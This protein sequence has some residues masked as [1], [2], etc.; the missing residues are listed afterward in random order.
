MKLGVS[1]V[2]FVIPGFASHY[3]WFQIPYYLGLEDDYEMGLSFD[4]SRP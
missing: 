3:W 1:Q 4:L 2:P